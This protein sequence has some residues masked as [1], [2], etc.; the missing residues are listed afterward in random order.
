MSHA[1]GIDL[2]G[3]KVLAGVIHTETGKVLSKVKKRTHAEHS[4]EDLVERMLS[5][6]RQAIAE[7]GVSASKI[8]TAGIGVAGQIDREQG[9][10]IAA[11]N[12]ANMANVKLAQRIREQLDLPVHLFNDVEA[13]AAGE[14]AFGAGKGKRD[15]LVVFVGTGIGGMIYRDG[16]PYKGATETAGEIGHT[17]VD[18]HGRLCACGGIGHVEAYASR[19]AIVR[20]IL[21]GMHAGR[22]SILSEV[23]LEI[24][25]NDP[26][27]SG[28][29]SGAIADAVSK[30][31]ALVRETLRTASDYLAA[32]L[33]SAFNF[34]NPPTIILGG[35][36]VEAVDWFFELVRK[37]A[38]N[39]T[40]AAP[41][42]H[43]EIIK[44][45][46]GDYSGIVG[47]AVL[48]SGQAG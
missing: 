20:V 40:L 17:V 38:I 30:H 43:V 11:P 28:I 34:Y 26:G 22:E 27:G 39:A 36:L 48:A 44:T 10:V 33:A 31:D 12:L 6:A 13:A 16:R 5:A 4:P 18:V 9:I 15:F 24:N 21:S 7:S 47:A 45:G 14:A 2:G 19:T 42:K 8:H 46:L 41:R 37:R 32:S 35:G 29:R 23:A 25:P 1:L 3:T